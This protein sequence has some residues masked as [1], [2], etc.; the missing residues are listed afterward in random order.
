M[1]SKLL[2]RIDLT[3]ESLV[4]QVGEQAD[5]I[6]VVISG[7]IILRQPMAGGASRE[8]L[9]G[10]GAVFGAADVICGTM[11]SASA[12][13][14]G[15][16]RITSHLPEE[17]LNA[18][19]DQPESADTMVASLLANPQ[20]DRLAADGTLE[21]IGP[22]NVKLM[23]L[24]TKIIDQLGG[25]PVLISQ[26]PFIVGRKSEKPVPDVDLPVSLSL[27]DKRPFNL[28]QCHFSIDREDG[29]FCV[30]D[31]R[32]YHGTIVNG[33]AIGS[34]AAALKAALL[35]GENEI[36]AGAEG[37]PFRFSCLVPRLA[38]G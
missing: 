16:T 14:H 9:I 31:Y 1:V 12:R 18:M 30:R 10:P 26:F 3:D 34:N 37:S 25:E 32:S 6:Y 27:I 29:Q 17:V 4:Y 33:E 2:Q 22:N 38:A 21:T 11:R 7:F 8:R 19:L 24:E 23:P 35:P 15:E 13:A 28:S 5:A 36:V 20:R